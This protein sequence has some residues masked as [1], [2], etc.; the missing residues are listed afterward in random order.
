MIQNIKRNKY[1]NDF[2][3]K[4]W[5][6]KAIYVYYLLYFRVLS[7]NIIINVKGINS[8]KQINYF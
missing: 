6:L 2:C 1:M 3:I 8:L 7:I 4:K 5:K